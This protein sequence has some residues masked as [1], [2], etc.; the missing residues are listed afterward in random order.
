[1]LKED[2]SN[3]AENET[4]LNTVAQAFAFYSVVR[5]T[6]ESESLSKRWPDVT[7]RRIN[8]YADELLAIAKWATREEGDKISFRII[9]PQVYKHFRE[10][11]KA[12]NLLKTLPTYKHSWPTA[13]A[14]Q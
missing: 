6:F 9:A 5:A 2:A 11:I 12:D 4:R 10:N 7:I 1:M 8:L 3:N 13:V 14:A